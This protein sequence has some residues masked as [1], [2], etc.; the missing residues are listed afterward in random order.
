[1]VGKLGAPASDE[2][3]PR[4]DPRYGSIVPNRSVEWRRDGI[5]LAGSQYTMSSSSWFTLEHR[6]TAADIEARAAKRLREGD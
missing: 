3:H 5:T 1:M 4:A 6:P 2:D